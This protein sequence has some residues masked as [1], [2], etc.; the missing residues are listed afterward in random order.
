MILR[1]DDL[2][3]DGRMLLKRILEN[4]PEY[5]NWILPDQ[6]R[7]SRRL[8]WR[9]FDFNNRLT[10]YWPTDRRS[11]SQEG[12]VF[13]L[14]NGIENTWTYVC[15]EKLTVQTCVQ[16]IGVGPNISSPSGALWTPL[17]AESDI[18]RTWH[19]WFLNLL[20]IAVVAEFCSVLTANVAACVSPLLA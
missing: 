18:F 1:S 3:I 10:L 5:V 15:N 17:W 20:I 7:T 8:S 4:E 19:S 13:N 2:D 14:G 16:N 11:A 6:D 12:F 9:T